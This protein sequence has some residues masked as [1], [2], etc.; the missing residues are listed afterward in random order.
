MMTVA[1]QAVRLDA[2]GGCNIMQP[3]NLKFHI[4]QRRQI[5]RRNRGPLLPCQQ[6]TVNR[7]GL[8]TVFNPVERR[9]ARFISQ[10][11]AGPAVTPGCAADLRRVPACHPVEQ[12]HGTGMGDQGTQFIPIV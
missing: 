1:L 7:N 3:V 9:Q 6:A 8:G 10:R 2:Q 12:A 4:A 5:A 11:I